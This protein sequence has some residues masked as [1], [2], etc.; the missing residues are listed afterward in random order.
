MSLGFSI[1]AAV[2]VAAQAENDELAVFNLILAIVFNINFLLVGL[3][4]V[5]LLVDGLVAVGCIDW[6]GMY[7]YIVHIQNIQIY[8]TCK[9]GCCKSE[10]SSKCTAESEEEISAEAE[11]TEAQTVESGVPNRAV[12]YDQDEV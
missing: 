2:N 11:K 7:I 10:C 8:T 1:E 9:S 12:I 5:L 4:W 3:F 6:T